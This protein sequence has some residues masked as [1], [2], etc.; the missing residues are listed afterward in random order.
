M[1]VK[2]YEET[3]STRRKDELSDKVKQEKLKLQKIEELNALFKSKEKEALTASGNMDINMLI[4]GGIS[5][6]LASYLD[7]REGSTV[8]DLA[9]YRAH[10][11]KYE[12]EFLE[13]LECLGVKPPV[14]LTRVT[15]YIDAIIQY[16]EKIIENG[17]AYVVNESVYFDTKAFQDAGHAY[18]KLNPW[19]VGSSELASE[20]ESNFD[21]SEKKSSADFA[22][23][24]KSKIGEPYWNSPWGKGRPGWHIEC[25]A[26]AS[27]VIGKVV[28][29]HSGGVDLR[30]PHHDN[31][32]AQAE[33]YFG[34]SQWVNYFIHSGHL[35]IEGLKMSKSLKNFVTIRE[36][37]QNYTARQL[38][39]LFVNQ[40]W[41][42]PIN[43]SEAVMNEA[44]TKEKQFL[45]FFKIVKN[46]LRRKESGEGTYADGFK[47]PQKWGIEERELSDLL[48]LTATQV[49][50]RL[51]DNFDTP[52]ALQSLLN[53][54]SGVHLYIDRKASAYPVP[55]LVKEAAEYIT[56]IL[57]IFGLSTANSANEIGF[58][59]E[60][61]GNTGGIETIV[62]PYINAACAL[63]DNV[64]D[65]ARENP[66]KERL[67]SITDHF[68][69]N[70]MVDLGVRVEDS[71]SGTI[72]EICDPTSL[73]KERDEKLRK[74]REA[75]IKSLES[76]IDRKMKEL[77][78]LELASA[79]PKDFFLKQTKKYRAFSD[80]GLPT[81]DSEGK[82]LSKKA[83]KDAEKLMQKMEKEHE[84]CKEKMA[85]DPS[86]LEK[87]KSELEDLNKHLKELRSADSTNS[88]HT[89]PCSSKSQ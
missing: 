74:A 51:E 86:F 14:V 70:V 63:R 64:R 88:G 46:F 75:A 16:I 32:L 21:N 11:A 43:Y 4:L 47:N 30:F 39:F 72:W 18:G 54:T 9:I 20:S 53:L 15:E 80:R 24:K 65:A 41:D 57:I 50:D 2:E 49:R 26:M 62:G 56:R 8:T 29:I 35:A 28:D 68:R 25:S 69:D 37:L 79:D 48:S 83:V 55:M 89:W 60:S 84:K 34:C 78:K 73:A 23:W 44:I 7:S 87:L 1:A 27:D 66:T 67:I 58:G 10:A 42:K 33:S 40:S 3:T 6:V 12:K 5:D 76:K 31:E 45:N 61:G 81:H 59:S 19:A 36:A 17:F 85:A 77:E 71:P 52:G 22:L 38:R 82:E 13:D